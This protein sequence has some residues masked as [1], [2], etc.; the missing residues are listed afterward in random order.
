MTETSPPP[1]PLVGRQ[2]WLIVALRVAVAVAAMLAAAAVAVPGELGENLGYAVV[3]L[4]IA[5]PV[6]RVVWLAIRWIRRGDLRFAGV[7]GLVLA[8]VAT[9]ALLAH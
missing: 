3:T 6:A 9:A 1:H 5:A 7:A 2:R 4:I 8:V